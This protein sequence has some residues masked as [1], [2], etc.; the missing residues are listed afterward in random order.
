MPVDQDWC[1]GGSSLKCPLLVPESFRRP[2]RRILAAA[3][4]WC[5]LCRHS[6]C[7]VRIV[8]GAALETWVWED[9]SPAPPDGPS[10]RHA[11]EEE[12]QSCLTCGLK[13][14]CQSPM[15]LP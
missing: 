3:L 6:Q 15:R 7:F 5:L 10:L 11:A 13:S 8:D 14:R 2:F 4:R 12:T 9:I 1:S